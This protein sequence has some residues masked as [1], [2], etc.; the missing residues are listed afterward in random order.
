MCQARVSF[1]GVCFEL[2]LVIYIY[3]NLVRARRIWE[4]IISSPNLCGFDKR[5]FSI[6]HIYFYIYIHLLLR[7]MFSFTRVVCS[8]YEIQ[9]ILS[10]QII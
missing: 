10:I 4:I 2:E 5:Y 1:H 6:R 3:I 9:E 8:A 7:K